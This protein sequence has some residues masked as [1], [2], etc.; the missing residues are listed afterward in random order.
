M[1]VP[2]ICSGKVRRSIYAGL[3]ES[4]EVKAVRKFVTKDDV[5]IDAGASLGFLSLQIARIVG[6]S[7]LYTVEANP[8]LLSCIEANF[9]ENGIPLPHLIHGLVEARRHRTP[10]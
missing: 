6:S 5:V 7:R 1:L 9:R 2:D 3:Y 4:S 8:G 10:L